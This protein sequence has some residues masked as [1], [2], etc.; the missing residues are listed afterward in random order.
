MNAKWK[1]NIISFLT[2]CTT[3]YSY[4]YYRRQKFYFSRIALM[5]HE[6]HHILIYVTKR[7]TFSLWFS[8]YLYIFLFF[9]HIYAII[10]VYMWYDKASRKAFRKM[11]TI[12]SCIRTLLYYFIIYIRI[13]ILKF[14]LEYVRMC[15]K[16]TIYKFCCSIFFLCVLPVSRH[17]LKKQVL[18]YVSTFKKLSIYTFQIYYRSSMTLMAYKTVLQKDFHE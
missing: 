2:F 18:S 14:I 16:C 8:V 7:D 12:L 6:D 11:S 13:H 3:S 10:Y 17:C 15:E 1:N 5:W 9:F 4:I